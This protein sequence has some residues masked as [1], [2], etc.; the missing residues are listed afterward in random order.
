MTAVE[1]INL[2]TIEEY[3]AMPENERAEVIND[4]LKMMSSPSRVHQ[5][6]L[7]LLHFKIYS[8]I[9]QR[10]G[11]CKVFPAPFD[12]MLSEK[13]LNIV[14][15]DIMVVCDKNKL[16]DKRCNGA[17]DFVIEIVSPSNSVYDY[18]TKANLYFQSGVREYWIVDPIRK[19]VTVNYFEDE[20]PNMHYTFDDEIKVNIYDDLFIDFKEVKNLL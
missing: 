20:K 15:P 11:G 16:D 5:E 14:Q 17:P 19:T 9:T 3:E 2:T 12:V 1:K 13:P 6:I 4:E 7:S 8:Y 10:K 18:I